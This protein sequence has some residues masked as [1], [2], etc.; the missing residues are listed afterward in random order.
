MKKIFLIAFIL[1]L[2]AQLYPQW[3]QTNGPSG[4]IIGLMSSSGQNAVMVTYPDIYSNSGA[5]LYI[6][7]DQGLI[8]KDISSQQPDSSAFSIASNSTDIFIG[9]AKGIFHS[10]DKGLTWIDISKGIKINES[11]FYDITAIKATDNMI[12]AGSYNSAYKSTDKGATWK[13]ISSGLPKDIFT[14]GFVISDFLIKDSYIFAI[15]GYYYGEGMYRYKDTS[16]TKLSSGLPDTIQVFS[17]IA[18]GDTIFAGTDRG[19][20]ASANNG[21]LWKPSGNG[22]PPGDFVTSLAEADSSIIAGTFSGIFRSTDKGNNWEPAIVDSQIVFLEITN[23]AVMGKNILAGTFEGMYLSNNNGKTWRK[24]NTGI[25]STYIAS[26]AA[27][28]NTI[29]AGSNGIFRSTDK[30]DNWQEV[31]RGLISTGFGYP[32]I[33]KLF[34]K[35]SLIFAASEGLGVF[36]S[37]DNGQSWLQSNSGFSVGPDSVIDVTTFAG[38]GSRIFAATY[39]KGV[40]LTTD[41]GKNW[42]EVSNGLPKLMDSIKTRYSYIYSLAAAGNNVLAGTNYQ[43]I[44]TVF[45]S[46]DNGSS[47][48]ETTGLL[49]GKDIA[50]FASAGSH[51]FAGGEG[52]MYISTDAGLSWKK[53]GGFVMDTMGTDIYVTA[54]GVQ[55]SILFASV[56]ITEISQFNMKSTIF[57]SNDYGNTWKEIHTGLPENIGINSFASTD[58]YIY[59]GT[60]GRG[61]WKLPVS[62][63]AKDKDQLAVQSPARFMLEQNYPNPFNPVT[64]I[65]YSV[66]VDSRV[67]LII[68]NLLGEEIITLINEAVKAGKYE[69]IFKAGALPSGVYFYTLDASSASGGK[70][71]RS[72]KK[73]ILLK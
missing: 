30:G 14:V 22:M 3:V 59:A 60:Y 41:N 58:D 10:T 52:G 71:F 11:G 47:W 43:K 7:T 54:L 36:I 67:K 62:A 34:L 33:N 68:Y 18:V 16:W 39:N 35:D 63:L 8:W 45:I 19:L 29:F 31:N 61:V 17:L 13:D 5:A 9:G 24:A 25:I 72:T 42:K 26:L 12:I 55:D 40:Y 73:F 1:V 57:R 21:E 28:G 70:N 46:T 23:L 50:D 66:P 38:S 69:T 20:F 4:G 15:S 37:T 48:K 56:D 51:M 64:T 49:K 44:N 53:T 65:R 6:T 27:R 32:F 2:S